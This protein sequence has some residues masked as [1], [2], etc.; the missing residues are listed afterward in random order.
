MMTNPETVLLQGAALLK[1]IFLERGFVFAELNSGESSGGQFS[2]AEFK[3]GDRR[4]EFHFRFSLGM[5][6]YHL[7][8]ESISHEE[9]MC[10]VLGK[11]SVSRYPVFSNN[12]L[13]AFIHL[14]DDIQN[15]CAEFLEGTNET[16]QSRIES[17]HAC[18]AGR[19]KLPG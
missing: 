1:P 2:S 15:H 4:F 17:A 18:W 6:S 8:S 3:R 10:S 7:G 9:Y 16:F 12:P 13:D 11:P 19:P 5:V 14:R